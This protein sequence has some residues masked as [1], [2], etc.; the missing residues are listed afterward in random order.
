[1][2][3]TIDTI[4]AQQKVNCICVFIKRI[5]N[6]EQH[7]KA[8]IELLTNVM[9]EKQSRQRYKNRTVVRNRLNDENSPCYTLSVG[10]YM[11]KIR[12]FKRG[13]LPLM[14]EQSREGILC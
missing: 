7:V 13:L 3:K 12:A 1:M 8:G 11:T 14:T 4:Q 5:K 9:L 10:R 2:R 6:Y